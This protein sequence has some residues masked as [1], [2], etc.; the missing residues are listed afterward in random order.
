MALVRSID[1]HFE[2]SEE[3]AL[4]FD[5][6]ENTRKNIFVTGEAGTGKSTLLQYFRDHTTKKVAV[7]APTGVSAVNI[8]GQTIHSFFHFKPDITVDAARHIRLRKTRRKM[9]ASLDALVI[10]E[11]SMLRADL[12][13]SIDAFLRIYGPAKDLPFGGLQVIF[14]GDLYQLPPV[15]TSVEEK[16]FNSIYPSPFFFSAVSFRYLRMEIIRLT[17]IYRQ[18]E[19]SFIRLLNSIRNCSATFDEMNMLNRHVRTDFVPSPETFFIYL[20]TT[21]ALADR[22]NQSHLQRL[23]GA[24]YSLEGVVDG[25]F[26]ESWL[27]TSERLTLKDGA[28]VM[29]LNNDHQGRWVNGTIGKV[30]DVNAAAGCVRAQL[31]SGDKVDVEPYEWDMFRFKYNEDTETLESETIGSFIQ[32]PLRL[33]WA[34]TIHKSQGQTFDRVVV[35]LGR[36]AFSHGQVYVALSRCTSLDGLVLRRP[37]TFKDLFLDE[38]I[39]EFLAQQVRVKE[40]E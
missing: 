40:K 10:D 6:L 38:R 1:T 2:F 30:L 12:L 34:V 32:Y 20:T 5:R 33:A 18:R 39:G 7:L 37:V 8:R 25:D 35:D 9:F 24:E 23:P 4:A 27:P 31:S 19:E 11:A 13:D 28:Q 16:I 26:T 3:F 17:K 29:M 22:V 36:G 15:V 21:N 14:F